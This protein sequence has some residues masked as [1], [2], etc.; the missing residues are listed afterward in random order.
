VGWTREG[1]IRLNDLRY[2]PKNFPV[3]CRNREISVGL[4]CRDRLT[5]WLRDRIGRAKGRVGGAR[6]RVGGMR[7]RTRVN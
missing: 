6:D 7:D 3:T 5:V 4:N 2:I 1:F